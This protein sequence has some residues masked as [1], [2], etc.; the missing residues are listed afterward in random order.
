MKRVSPL[1][2]TILMLS[3]SG[4]QVLFAQ[5]GDNRTDF[6]LHEIKIAKEQVD[7]YTSPKE[8]LYVVDDAR[9]PFLRRSVSKSRRDQWME[10]L[11][12][13]T[14]AQKKSINDALDAL[15]V[16]VAKKLPFFIPE[17][18]NFALHNPAEEELLKAGVDD[19]SEATVHKFG[20]K[21]NWLIEKDSYNMPINK[22]RQGY[23]WARYSNDHPYC[24]LIQ[25]NL[26]AEYSGGGN[27]AEPYAKVVGVEYCACPK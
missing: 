25:V 9:A 3:A 21:T 1:L 24:N 14:P 22:Y 27:Y 8:K 20:F 13:M 19:L 17:D 7:S 15:G 5:E 10:E 6:F 2:L 4:Y 12:A 26:V 23:I 11:T 18:K 16:S